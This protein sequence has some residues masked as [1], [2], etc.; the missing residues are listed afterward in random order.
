MGA[1]S[2]LTV[3]TVLRCLGENRIYGA[4]L[5]RS[6]FVWLQIQSIFRDRIPWKEYVEFTRGGNPE[7]LNSPIAC[8]HLKVVGKIYK[9]AFCNIAGAKPERLI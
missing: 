7:N 5:L 4:E 6:G 8:I 2:R 1:V 9:A 3:S